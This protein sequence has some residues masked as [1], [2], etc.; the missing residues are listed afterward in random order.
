MPKGKC[1]LPFWGSVVRHLGRGRN[2]RQGA[3]FQSK[4]QSRLTYLPL[5]TQHHAS[6]GCL[7]LA[8]QA[9]CSR[10][11]HP[12]MQYWAQLHTRTTRPVVEAEAFHARSPVQHQ[13]R[14]L[15]RGPP[16]ALLVP[17]DPTTLRVGSPNARQH[18]RLIVARFRAWKPESRLR[19]S[20]LMRALL[21]SCQPR[22]TTGR[23]PVSTSQSN[24]CQWHC[25]SGTQKC[26]P[27][28]LTAG[29]MRSLRAGLVVP[30]HSLPP[31]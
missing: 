3:W 10:F 27:A 6:A 2:C 12:P 19:M 17:R 29:G 30:R 31:P 20:T 15:G 14:P 8:C 24:A 1:C 25:S 7:A 22:S 4:W 11:F 5:V 9:A 23:E 18:R 28:V 16:V 13:R 26:H 21:T